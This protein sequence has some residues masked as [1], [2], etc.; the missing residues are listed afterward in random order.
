MMNNY[1]VSV[2]SNQIFSTCFGGIFRVFPFF[3]FCPALPDG[4]PD[5]E[6]SI[7]WRIFGVFPSFDFCPALPDGDPDAEGSI[8]WRCGSRSL[9]FFKLH[10]SG[11]STFKFTD[12]GCER[13]ALLSLSGVG[14]WDLD[15]EYDGFFGP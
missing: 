1:S 9:F 14:R 6:G 12:V 15:N 2:E 8:L 4:D 11:R 5:A 7:L 3:D 13:A 10:L